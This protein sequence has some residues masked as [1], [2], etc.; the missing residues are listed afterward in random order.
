MIEL[1]IAYFLCMVLALY[2]SAMLGKAIHKIRRGKYNYFFIP[3]KRS[4]IMTMPVPTNIVQSGQPSAPLMRAITM[5]TMTKATRIPL[6][7]IVSP[8]S[9]GASIPR[10]KSVG[11]SQLTSTKERQSI[12]GR[13]LYH[14]ELP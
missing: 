2:L 11:Q 10:N 7:S 3:K 13:T 8:S 6:M 5:R 1:V 14:D 12:K 9:F 4:G